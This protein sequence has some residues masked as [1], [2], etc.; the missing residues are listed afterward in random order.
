MARHRFGG[1][2]QDW[3]FRRRDNVDGQNGIA[4]LVAATITFWNLPEGGTQYTDLLDEGGS[5]ITEVTSADGTGDAELGQIPQF[6]GPDGVWTMWASADGGP[7][8]LM[9]AWDFGD[10]IDDLESRVAALE[11]DGD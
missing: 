7:R 5:P 6:R 9:S 10:S 8:A 2:I 3:T 11:G 4:Q 1:G